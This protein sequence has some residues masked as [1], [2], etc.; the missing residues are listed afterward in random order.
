M[1]Q[2]SHMDWY[3]EARSAVL[4]AQMDTEREEE[5]ARQSTRAPF[6]EEMAEE[7]SAVRKAAEQVGRRVVAVAEHVRIRNACLSTAKV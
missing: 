7:L 4:K 3:Q 1:S 2:V 6:L 5:K